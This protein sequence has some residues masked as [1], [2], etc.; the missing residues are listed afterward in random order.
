MGSSGKLRG[1]EAT[2]DPQWVVA[3]FLLE[4]LTSCLRSPVPG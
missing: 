4:P 2:L 3:G 1:K